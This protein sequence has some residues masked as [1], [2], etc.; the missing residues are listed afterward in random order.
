MSFG[1]AS[2]T[3][4]CLLFES[5][6]PGFFIHGT[7]HEPGTEKESLGSCQ[8]MV[9][10]S[11]EGVAGP[12]HVLAAKVAAAQWGAPGAAAGWQGAEQSA[13]GHGAPLLGGAGVERASRGWRGVRKAPG[14]LSTSTAGRGEGSGRAAEEERRTRAWMPRTSDV[15]AR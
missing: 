7:E 12:G 15:S 3:L 14:C 4:S 11:K 13:G 6:V 9:A 10:A 1:F 5:E 8:W 2:G